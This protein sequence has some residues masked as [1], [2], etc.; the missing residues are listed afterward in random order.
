M[1]DKFDNLKWIL[2]NDESVSDMINDLYYKNII[3][4]TGE[5]LIEKHKK[6]SLEEVFIEVTKWWALF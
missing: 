4:I 6:K 2:L 1:D 5:Q 3:Q